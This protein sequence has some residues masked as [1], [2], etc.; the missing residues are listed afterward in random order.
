MVDWMM[1]GNTMRTL[2]SL[3]IALAL[4]LSG[5]HQG[6]EIDGIAALVLEKY[7]GFTPLQ[8]RN[9]IESNED[10]LAGEMAHIDR[11]D[12]YACVR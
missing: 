7:P 6:D 1:R 11:V 8:V 5:C 3:V 9:W 12:A 10:D 4:L 2:P